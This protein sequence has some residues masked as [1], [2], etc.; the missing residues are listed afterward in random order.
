MLEALDEEIA[1][2]RATISSSDPSQST[3]D[4]GTNGKST[5]GSGAQ[6]AKYHDIDDVVRL[7]RLVKAKEKTKASL[8]G[9]AAWK[10]MEAAKA[11]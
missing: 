3:G 5:P 11:A 8:E 1:S 7:E 10:G 4:K 6:A 9:R 2:L